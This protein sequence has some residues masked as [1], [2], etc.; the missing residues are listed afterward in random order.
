M[1]RLF[2]AVAAA[3]SLA[4]SR[5]FGGSIDG[6]TWDV[7]F[8]PDSLLGFSHSGTLRFDHGEL[9]AA[10][11]LAQGLVTGSYDAKSV[12][13]PSGTVWSAALSEAE[14]GVLSCQGLITGDLIEGMAVLWRPDGKAQ[15]FLFKGTRKSA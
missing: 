4:Y 2:L 8:R 12:T 10:L 7:K 5:W 1:K 11:P 14:R 3:A 13:G 15:R 6:T 9:I